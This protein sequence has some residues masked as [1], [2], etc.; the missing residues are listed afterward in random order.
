MTTG[1]NK[2]ESRE[3]LHATF[4]DCNTKLVAKVAELKAQLAAAQRD[5]AAVVVQ[6]L[7]EALHC[8]RD[9][10]RAERDGYA[11]VPAAIR[12]ER[13]IAEWRAGKA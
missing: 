3:A 11:V 6:E 1:A 5:R 7:T 12:I 13:R 10:E 8:V 9:Q 2:H 4:G